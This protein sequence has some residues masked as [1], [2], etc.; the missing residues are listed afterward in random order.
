[1]IRARGD[2]ETTIVYPR[3][4][5]YRINVEIG[6]ALIICRGI[7]VGK[8]SPI[9]FFIRTR[10]VFSG[11]VPGCRLLRISGRCAFSRLNVAVG[12]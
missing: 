8:R 6:A 11:I 9:W 1:M 7:C 3:L 12:K 4:A 2:I 5:G 10:A